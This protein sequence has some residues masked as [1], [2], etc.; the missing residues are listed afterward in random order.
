MTRL[1]PFEVKEFSLARQVVG[2]I[3][4]FLRKALALP[5]HFVADCVAIDV[6]P[7]PTHVG[8]NAKCCGNGALN[9]PR[10]HLGSCFER[11]PLKDQ[12]RRKEKLSCTISGGCFQRE[13][14]RTSRGER[15]DKALSGSG[16]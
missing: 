14:L 10:P 11:E 4:V 3:C 2:S 12:P 6:F 1:I 7:Q 15:S 9:H 8:Q 5:L 13:V 16:A